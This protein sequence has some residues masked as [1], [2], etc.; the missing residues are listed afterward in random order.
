LRIGGRWS[1]DFQKLHCARIKPVRFLHAREI[2]NDSM[3]TS[4][5]VDDGVMAK[6]SSFRR[7]S[8]NQIFAKSEDG[9]EIVEG[10][11]KQSRNCPPCFP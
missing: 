8:S 5:L 3:T 10:N 6:P 7:P 9:H 2:A 4:Y 1:A 11:D